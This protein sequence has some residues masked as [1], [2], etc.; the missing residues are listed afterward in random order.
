ERNNRALLED[1][2]LKLTKDEVHLLNGG[3][4][5][6]IPAHIRP[7]A[8]MFD[9]TRW[10]D[11][12][13]AH[14]EDYASW[15]HNT[16]SSGFHKEETV[17]KIFGGLANVDIK[18][19]DKQLLDKGVEVSKMRTLDRV[20]EAQRAGILP[21]RAPAMRRLNVAD[22]ADNI[23]LGNEFSVRR[24]ML[25][26]VDNKIIEG[27]ME[28]ARMHATTVMREASARNASPIDRNYDPTQLYKEMKYDS[29]SGELRPVNM[30]R[31]KGQRR[32]LA[33]G[34]RYYAHAYDESITRPMADP[35]FKRALNEHMLRVR[36]PNVDQ[37]TL[38]K[39]ADLTHNLGMA[40]EDIVGQ[41]GSKG[42]GRIGRNILRELVGP[43]FSR[44]HWDQMLV[45]LAK[46]ENSA[47]I[48]QALQAYLP[49]YREPS[50]ED[51]LS[52]LDDHKKTLNAGHKEQVAAHRAARDT[53]LKGGPSKPYALPETPAETR[54][55][56][57]D[58][59]RVT[60]LIKGIETN[61]EPTVSWARNLPLDDR[62]FVAS[63]IN[64]QVVGGQESF[65]AKRRRLMAET[66]PV[67]P[68]LDEAGEVISPTPE[69][70]LYDNIEEARQAIIDHSRTGVL[71]PN[72]HD[73]GFTKSL[74]PLVRDAEGQFV[75][76]QA[77][78][79]SVVLY[80]APK[81]T[82]MTFEQVLATAR[83]RE[84]VSA[85][86][87]VIE[88][89][90]RNSDEAT[91]LI[92]NEALARELHHIDAA[93]AG[94]DV[95]VLGALVPAARDRLGMERTGVPGT[96]LEVRRADRTLDEDRAEAD[97]LRASGPPP[98]G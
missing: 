34:D 35:A 28:W 72:L 42:V 57:D 61:V 48:A 83:N 10:A 47:P 94:V 37:E 46:N 52:A 24:M 20:R 55:Y 66:P 43:D 50:I 77:R 26:G 76:T 22:Y 8:R 39:Y 36:S 2:P 90:L 29:K 59:N 51:V 16:L 23:L 82:D 74:R 18:A 53:R 6:A 54:K 41:P 58:L 75:E 12:A 98:R 70:W 91:P 31:V 84:L 62:H 27:G 87:G 56:Y 64:D 88:G 32:T 4:L 93:H 73:A 30:I 19:I 89:I 15:L 40:D 86:R 81:L 9:R 45:D 14:F 78:D 3:R 21:V 69:K 5:S 11:P 97:D 7:V 63:F 38:G 49:R 13:M 71:D 17:D 80:D 25:G 95:E 67:E 1:V 92:A 79:A 44:E 60:Q 96:A 85:N 33:N 65:W 68:Q